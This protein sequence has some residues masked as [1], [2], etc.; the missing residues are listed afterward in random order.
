MSR[1]ILRTADGLTTRTHSLEEAKASAPEGCEWLWRN[2]TSNRPAAWVAVPVGG[3]ASFA[4]AMRAR[5]QT[6]GRR[7]RRGLHSLVDR[8]PS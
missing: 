7:L 3:G 8:L 6:L 2:P 1:W 4:E 5:E